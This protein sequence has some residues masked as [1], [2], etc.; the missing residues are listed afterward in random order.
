MFASYPSPYVSG[1]RPRK[2]FS[3]RIEKTE[4]LKH[5][6]KSSLIYRKVIK[7][8]SKEKLKFIPIINY[9]LYVTLAIFIGLFFLSL[10]GGL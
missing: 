2:F 9:A 10:I 7:N 6:D 8:S 5:L 1:K 3:T 4:K